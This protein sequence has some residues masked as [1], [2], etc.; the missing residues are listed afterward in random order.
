MKVSPGAGIP[1]SRIVDNVNGRALER[2]TPEGAAEADP[3][4]ALRERASATSPLRRFAFNVNRAAGCYCCSPR[5]VA[6]PRSGKHSSQGS[7][8]GLSNSGL[9]FAGGEGAPGLL[10]CGLC[11]FFFGEQ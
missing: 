1:V 3:P 8:R 11:N 7:L 5:D 9:L 10:D 6:I 4:H 2:D